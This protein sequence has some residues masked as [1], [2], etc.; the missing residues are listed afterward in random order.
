MF[1]LNGTQ[2]T[3]EQV[4]EAAKA[5]N[6]TVEEYIT[7]AGLTKVGK[8]KPITQT[9]AAAVGTNT[10]DTEL[11]SADGSLESQDPAKGFFE[12]VFGADD[13]REETYEQRELRQTVE[14]E[15]KIAETAAKREIDP[16][17]GKFKELSSTDKMLNSVGN[18]ADQFQQFVP[19][20]VISSNK[21]FRGIFGDEAIDSFVANESI[22]EFFKEGLSDEDLD[23]AIQ[24]VKLQEAEMQSTGEITK[25]FAEGDVGEIA[26]GI[27]NGITSIGSSLAVNTLTAGGGLIPDMIGR[28]YIDY[29]EALAEEKGKTISDLVKDDE[30]E[31]LVPATIGVIGGIL[32]R[33]PLKGANKWALNRA[34]QLGANKTASAILISGLQEGATEW[35]QTGLEAANIAEAK[36]EDSGEAFVDMLTSRQGLESFLQG[37]VGGGVLGGAGKNVLAD[38]QDIAKASSVIRS[39]DQQNA[40]ESYTQQIAD[41]TKKRTKTKNKEV[42]KVIDRKIKEKKSQRDDLILEH[43][44][45]VGNMTENELYRSSK[46][47]DKVKK[48]SKKYKETQQKGENGIISSDEETLLLDDLNAKLDAERKTLLNIK[49]KAITRADESLEA[50]VATAQKE[51]A[52]L[53]NVTFKAFKTM[54]EVESYLLSKDKRKTKASKVMA[55][56]EDGIIYQNPDGSQEI[57][58]NKELAKK[59]GAINVGAHELLHGILYKTLKDKPGYA[60]KLGG[61]LEGEINKINA[62]Q[63]QDSV[64]RKR[65]ELYKDESADVKGEE[66][67]TLFSDATATGDIKFNDDLFT[68]LGSVF[69][70]IFDT[71]GYKRKFKTGRDVY[72]FVRDYNKDIS[73][74]GIR[75]AMIEA[76]EEGIEVDIKPTSKI[77]KAASEVRKASKSN[78][79]GLLEKYGNDPETLIGQGLS[80]TPQGQETF[81]F[82][83]SEFG[84]EVAPIVESLTKKLYDPIPEDAKRDVSRNDYKDAMISEL[85]TI[86]STEYDPAKQDIDTFTTIRAFQRSNRLA[87]NLGIESVQEFGGTGIKTDVTEAKGIAADEIEITANTKKLVDAIGV[88]KSILNKGDQTMQ[89]AII[90][91]ENAI[92]GKEMTPSQ[93]VRARDKA[94]SEVF[95]QQLEKDLKKEFLKTAKNNETFNSF[96]DK[97]WK[98]VAAVYLKN[99]NVNKI[100]EGRGK[101]IL[102]GW[103]EQFP[104]KQEVVDYFQGKDLDNKQAISNRKNRS[105]ANAIVKEIMSDRKQKFIKEDPDAVAEFETKTGIKFSKS[106]KDLNIK[107]PEAFAELKEVL[108]KQFTNKALANAKNSME[109]ALSNIGVE[110]I[111]KSAFGEGAGTTKF[112][113]LVKDFDKLYADLKTATEP[114]FE[115]EGKQYELAAFLKDKILGD[116]ENKSYKLVVKALTGF[117]VDID[118]SNP[119]FVNS[120]RR[121]LA[122]IIKPL[123]RSFFER[124]LERGMKAPSKIGK[125]DLV[126]EDGKLVFN[127]SNKKDATNRFGFFQ[128]ADDVTA[129]KNEVFGKGKENKNLG[130]FSSLTSQVVKTVKFYGKKANVSGDQSMFSKK[131]LLGI[132][133]DTLE[134]NKAFVKLINALKEA[135]KNDQ[136][137]INETVAILM[138]MNNNPLGLTRT[139][140]ILEHIPTK[141]FQNEK[142]TLE[143][144]IPALSVNL[145][146]LDHILSKEDKT[147]F[148][149]MMSNYRITYLP[150]SY[151]DIVNKFYKAHMPFYWNFDK[152]A[153]LRYFNPEMAN[154]FD[155]EF[156]SIVNGTI[157]NA[158]TFNVEKQQSKIKSSKSI[159]KIRIFDFD[160]TLAQ[161]NSQVLYTLPNGTTGKL[162]ATEYAKRDQELKDK[163]ATFNFSEFSKVIDG[164]KGPLFEVAQKIN[165]ARGNEDLFVLTARPANAAG[166]IQKFLK[167]AGLDFKKQNIIG[168][169]DGTAQAKADWTQSK[170]NEG[171]NDFYFADDAIKNVEAVKNVLDNADVKGKVQQAKVKSSKSLDAD[172]NA[173]LER[174]KGVKADARYS[175]DRA[176]K[177]GA[178]KGKFKFFIPYSAEDFVGLIYPTLG[179][180]AEGDKN[181]QWYKDNILDPYA[182][183]YRNFEAAKQLAMQQWADLKKQI[184]K[185]PANLKKESVR[186]FSN[187]E[188]VRVY[189]WD[190]QNS[191]PDTLAKKDVS[192][193]VKH[194][195]NTP[196]LLDFATQVNNIVGAGKYPSPQ[197]DWLAGTITTD[198][199]NYTNTVSRKEYLQEWQD[200]VDVVY[201]KDNLNK[202]KALYGNAYVEALQDMLYRM[203]T[204]RN[205]PSGSNKLTNQFMNWI[206]DSVGTIMF[207]NTRSALLQTISSVNY[208]NWSDNNPVKAAAAFANQKQFWNDFAEIFNSDFLKQRRSGLK[209]DVNADEIARMASTADN[210]VRAALS[211]ILKKG[212][213]P[214][215][216]ADSFAISIGGT[217]FYRNRINTYLKEGLS[218][219]EAKEKAFLDF[220]EITEESQQSSRPDRVS[221]QQASPL[222]RV[223]LAFANTPMQ[224]G[225]LMKKAALDL[226]NGRGDW[227]T[228]TSKILYYG[229]I[230]NLIFTFLQQAMFAMLFS[231]DDDDEEQDRYFRMGNSIA[232]SLL[233]GVG[234]GGAVVATAKNL[235]MKTIEEYKSGRPD[236][237][238]VA[239][240]LTTL[241]PPINSKLRK[242]QSAGRSFTYKQTREEMREKGI[243]IDNPAAEAGGKIISALTNVPADRAIR[244]MN[245]LKTATDQDLEMWQ[246]IALALGYSKWDVG[247]K[248]SS[249]KIKTAE[250]MLREAFRKKSKLPFKKKKRKTK[251]KEDQGTFGNPFK[252]LEDGV[253][254][255][256]HKDG[257]IEV[258]KGLS[259]AKKKEVVA[260]EKKHIADMKSGKLD[261]DD[262]NVYWNG[263]PYPRLQGKKIVYNGV[264]YL[265]G[266]KKLPWEKSANNIKV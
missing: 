218:E 30:D 236:Y 157:V 105:L 51:A 207:F 244:K 197:G 31:V 176:T 228:N 80:K 82:T 153:F 37:T 96:L 184:K 249:S 65:L 183:G 226:V 164:K 258:K 174:V 229:A 158:A 33:L 265:E 126:L 222:G 162:N 208:L 186:G 169:G 117:N 55:Q 48:L 39:T 28:A 90:K 121:S 15:N 7:K 230:Q 196:E 200:N 98:E 221:M 46:I 206:N 160:D 242:L 83:K 205:R 173:M 36:D 211:A 203:K 178:K 137:G 257:T 25:G 179:K 238:D 41:L 214:T 116:L 165:A 42:L 231:D 172:F 106:L 217:S 213:L 9:T 66:V 67:L 139:S 142:Y 50:N 88:S 170:V 115:Y 71:V 61:L 145:A 60:V 216:L 248:N 241:S 99:T 102:Q 202:L 54:D 255:K 57:I 43:N 91:A 1:E 118:L 12:Q 134:N 247:I 113:N 210:K 177:L 86:I 261:Y 252:K 49:T 136:I 239:L 89:R 181:M 254:G 4:E 215:Q 224:Y 204:G 11:Q 56:T 19:N 87:K 17:T 114:T 104:S 38:K 219:K 171:Y 227:K 189:L 108:D 5:S 263:K 223:I 84:Q 124:Y 167:L 251:R 2:Y 85:A 240:E 234:V 262:Q 81:E 24:Q 131:Q 138:A 194:V 94:L 73:K 128:N 163:G 191:V 132:R 74:G 175:E 13:D 68:K 266:H 146:A 151:D 180:G 256:A 10:L 190:K 3:L 192:E 127:P 148:S 237:T 47:Y 133:K 182:T 53:K 152:T 69:R 34:V 112:N 45:V 161:S 32:E 232:D 125:G 185:T 119:T 109:N 103:N 40:I 110:E 235:A 63:V 95:N 245:N 101:E 156:E 246:S 187:E 264:A 188:A 70:R 199:V 260:H 23:E 62:D 212:F 123:G 93:K 155:V 201:S 220:K 143:H 20:L 35:V 59:T 141:R 52:K 92:V 97:N 79:K 76:A 8:Q 18:M 120:A 22:P 75:Q 147:S 198:L 140:A 14:L 64:F 250:E 122:K 111:F 130:N 77:Q 6:I 243:A 233:R 16:E 168:L 225:R 107:S 149:D 209:T 78:L 193:L 129:W 27:V 72:N 58:I 21:I 26:A 159:K 195:E 154:E 259:P 44:K 144:M 150:K 166:P 100:P 135:N 29:N 253:L